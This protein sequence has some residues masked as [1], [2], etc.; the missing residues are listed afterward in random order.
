MT[1]T[2]FPDPSFDPFLTYVQIQHAYL[3][4]LTVVFCV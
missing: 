1:P 2:F 4:L 3:V